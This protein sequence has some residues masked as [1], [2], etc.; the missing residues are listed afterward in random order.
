MYKMYH[1]VYIYMY[2]CIYIYIILYCIYNICNIFHI[3][4]MIW[5]LIAC[6]SRSGPMLQITFF[7]WACCFSR[8]CRCLA[9][10]FR[11]LSTDPGDGWRL[12]RVQWL[13]QNELAFQPSGKFQ[14]MRYIAY[15]PVQGETAINSIVQDWQSWLYD[16]LILLS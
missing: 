7:N 4:I 1:N 10:C 3:D 11:N 9:W 16:P 2:V 8:N 14:F 6:V 15:Q 13:L 5:Y 12:D